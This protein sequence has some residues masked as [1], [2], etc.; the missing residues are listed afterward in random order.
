MGERLE[1]GTVAVSAALVL[2]GR[3]EDD[4]ADENKENVLFCCL[5]VAGGKCHR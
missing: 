5:K 1:D 2:D 3:V 4:T